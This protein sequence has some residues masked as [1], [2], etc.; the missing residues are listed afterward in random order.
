MMTII[1]LL[2]LDF[3]CVFKNNGINLLLKNE[4]LAL[5]R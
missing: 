3:F 2:T 1:T 4:W 5:S